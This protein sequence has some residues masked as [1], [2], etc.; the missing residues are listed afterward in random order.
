MIGPCTDSYVWMYSFII[1]PA[2]LLSVLSL[3]L[4]ISLNFLYSFSS[5][6]VCILGFFVGILFSKVIDS[7]SLI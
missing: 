3:I 6:S 4:H 7:Y 5:N 2:C 1:I